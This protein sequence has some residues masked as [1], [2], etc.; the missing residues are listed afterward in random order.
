MIRRGAKP[1]RRRD[2]ERR[3]NAGTR[4][5]AFRVL[6]FSIVLLS[7]AAGYWV[8][9][10]GPALDT[11][12]LIVWAD[13]FFPIESVEVTEVQKVSRD[14]VLAILNLEGARGLLSTDP[15]KVKQSLESHPWMQ[16]A[17]FRRV[18]A[19]TRGAALKEREPD[20]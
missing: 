5:R 17:D 12:K 4:R 20:A 11:M 15:A 18:C 9:L 1:N 16:Q 14:E 19:Y 13:Q 8:G 6:A 10:R 3:T 7:G 2:S